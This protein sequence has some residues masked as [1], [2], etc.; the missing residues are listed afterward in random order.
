MTIGKKVSEKHR[1][2][3]SQTQLICP[4]CNSEDITDMNGEYTCR[5]C[6]LVLETKVAVYN[7]PYEKEHE[8][9]H[10][11]NRYSQTQIGNAR[12]RYSTQQGQKYRKLQKI[13]RSKTHKKYDESRTK[14]EINRIF[15]LLKLP[16]RLR[17]AVFVKYIEVWAQLEAGTKFR[18]SQKLLPPLIYLVH[19]SAGC[20]INQTELM[21]YTDIEK[22][23][24]R[25]GILLIHQLQPQ[26]AKRNR[27]KYI[28]RKISQV[29]SRLGLDMGFYKLSVQILKSFWS[30]LYNTSDNIIAGVV[31]SIATLTAYQ[32]HTNVKRIC[33]K[34]N[35]AM[36][37]IQSQVKRKIVRKLELSG[38]TSLVKS[39]FLLKKVMIKMG[40]IE[41]E[42]ETQKDNG[43]ELRDE[44]LEGDELEDEE[45]ELEDEEDELE[46]GESNEDESKEDESEGDLIHQLLTNEDFI[47]FYRDIKGFRKA[48]ADLSYMEV[49]FGDL[50]P[51]TTI[52]L[53]RFEFNQGTFSP[54]SSTLLVLAWKKQYAIIGLRQGT[55]RFKLYPNKGPPLS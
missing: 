31:M 37:T 23:D 11:Y 24:F 8:H 16:H 44:K 2:E 43:D 7:S 54:N 32:E 6:G 26:L 35:I 33:D 45:D 55:F 10:R 15:T 14:C 38:F 1:D 19:K 5:A 17:K 30:D 3:L 27:G 52:K 51:D 22:S 29:T 9:Y 42:L 49:S 4:E 47:Q 36:S 18:G 39:A 28:V 34:L 12:E 46:V 40:L 48:W 53:F 41:G 25:E 13:N 50:L 20:P 21:E